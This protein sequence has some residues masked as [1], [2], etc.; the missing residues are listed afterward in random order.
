MKY[1]GVG[2][3]VQPAREAARENARKASTVARTP[4]RTPSKSA[5]A[6]V[7]KP[8]AAP[9]VVV[10][11]WELRQDPLTSN[12]IAVWVPTG[13]VRVVALAPLIKSN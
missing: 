12:L 6:A 7:V 4:A 3:S 9:T 13:A 2:S 8:A 11:N 5:A 1:R 10:G